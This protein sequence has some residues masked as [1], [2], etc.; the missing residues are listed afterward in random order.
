MVIQIFKK[1]YVKES[2]VIISDTND[3]FIKKS[4][5]NLRNNEFLYYMN[6]HLTSYMKKNTYKK[7]VI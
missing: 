6:N 3:N 5:E 1:S 2:L 7:K 4:N